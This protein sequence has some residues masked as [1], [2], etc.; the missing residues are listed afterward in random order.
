MSALEAFLG[1]RPLGAVDSSG[2]NGALSPSSQSGRSVDSSDDALGPQNLQHLSWLSEADQCTVARG[3]CANALREDRRILRELRATIDGYRSAAEYCRAVATV[4]P[5]W[6]TADVQN[7]HE[8]RL[9]ILTEALKELEADALPAPGNFQAHDGLRGRI[10][11]SFAHTAD[12]AS[13]FAT[14]VEDQLPEPERMEEQVSVAA[15]KGLEVG[16]AAVG[17]VKTAFSQFQTT[18]AAEFGGLVHDDAVG[19]HGAGRPVGLAAAPMAPMGLVSRP[20]KLIRVQRSGSE[21]F[22]CGVAEMQGWRASHEDAHAIRCKDNIGHFWVLDGHGGDATAN[23]SAPAL[24][25]HFEGMPSDEVVETGFI[26]ID[27]DL[28]EHLATVPCRTSGSTVTGALVERQASGTYAVKMVNAGDSRALI[29]IP[30]EDAAQAE[31]SLRAIV[32]SIRLPP[33]MSGDENE[34]DVPPHPE[35][36]LAT[37]DHKPSDPIEKARIEAIGGRVLGIMPPRVDGILA[38]SRALGDFDFK[39]E[40][41]QPPSAQKVT[42]IP[43]IYEAGNVPEGSL[44]ILA[45]DGVWDVMSNDDVA[46]FV[47]QRLR[48]DPEQAADLGALAAELLRFCFQRNSMDN[49]T[50]MLVHLRDGSR[51][52]GH[53]DEIVNFAAL[54]EVEAPEA[55]AVFLRKM[56]FSLPPKPCEDSKRWF[57]TTPGE[58]VG[59]ACPPG[60]KDTAS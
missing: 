3:E 35:V 24:A 38:V 60:C 16:R 37:R 58:A 13:K 25:G 11:N 18:L 26:K 41:S 1:G 31:A 53:P 46:N 47:W 28:R 20:V 10:I 33:H 55:H 21:A 14:D 5:A 2:D 15:Q 12:M 43:D 49:M 29:S 42:C 32:D 54:L 4:D 39:R 40:L 50:A 7:C 6:P 51:W 48:G 19:L 57:A 30:A 34:N 22:S 23:Y 9:D 36:V 8:K 56:G 52:R 45:C 59:N 17:A 44:V 27:A